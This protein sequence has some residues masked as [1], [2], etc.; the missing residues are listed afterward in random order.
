MTDL[1]RF[2]VTATGPLHGLEE[3]TSLLRSALGSDG[4]AQ[5]LPFPGCELNVHKLCPNLVDPE[6]SW[7]VLHGTT[8]DECIEIKPTPDVF[9]PEEEEWFG[10][11]RE[12]AGDSG[13]RGVFTWQW[14]WRRW[15]RWLQDRK[16]SVPNVAKLSLFGSAANGAPLGIVRLL[17][18]KHPSLEFECEALSP[19]FGSDS[20]SCEAGVLHCVESF[21][22]LPFW[23]MAVWYVV[24]G[25]ELDPP[26]YVDYSEPTEEEER[27]LGSEI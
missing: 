23:N 9:S 25:R 14:Q 20:F 7:V 19:Y 18:E 21:E 24:D 12:L 22:R 17:S 8:M 2:F 27:R 16:Q 6:Q 11:I 13:V 1:H 10:R 15:L 3:L 5:S 4:D 26:E